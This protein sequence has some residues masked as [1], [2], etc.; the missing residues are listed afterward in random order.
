GLV[1][2]LGSYIF[3]NT[4]N[5]QL[6]QLRNP[7]I[8]FKNETSGDL[9]AWGQFFGHKR[10]VGERCGSDFDC[11]SRLEC[12]KEGREAGICTDTGQ[13]AG[14]SVGDCGNGKECNIGFRCIN[15]V[16]GKAIDSNI[17]GS[18]KCTFQSAVDEYCNPNDI[19]GRRGCFKG[20][21]VGNKCVL[22][23]PSS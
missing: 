1:I 19:G 22:T 11:E 18:G 4:I 5:P 23:Q 12:K 13:G 15:D 9:T 2:L 7:T 8:Q 16:T 17:P 20:L 10:G 21:C 3:L 6:V 14:V